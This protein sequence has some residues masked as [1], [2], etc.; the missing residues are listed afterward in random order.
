[1]ENSCIPE[2]EPE[3]AVSK[4]WAEVQQEAPVFL[5]E[6]AVA[7]EQAVKEAALQNEAALEV[8][9][10]LCSMGLAGQVWPFA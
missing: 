7:V 4:S 5:T 8:C 10:T 3:T 6:A 9:G 2:Q 1:M